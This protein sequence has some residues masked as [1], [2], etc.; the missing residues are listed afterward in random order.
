MSSGRPRRALTQLRAGGVNQ[1]SI[2][3]LLAA[4]AVPLVEGNACTF[5]YRGPADAVEV[6]HAVV[7]LPQPL[8]LKR[9]RHSDLWHASIELPAGSRVEYRLTVRRNGMEESILDPL[10]HRVAR[11]PVGE[12]SVLEAAGYETPWWTQH[13]PE[14]VP[15]EHTE[16][17][18][19]SRALR[20]RAHV[21]LYSPARMREG[22]R[23]PL[24][25]LH[26]GGDFI[27]HAAMVD[28]LDNLMDRRLMADCVVAMTH[29]GDRLTEYAASPAHSRFLTTELVPELEK[30]LPLRAEPAGRALAGASFGAIAATAAAW[31][32]PGF[33]GSLLLQ[34][35]SFLWT[36]AGR[37]HPGGPD[38]D[39]VVRFVNEVRAAPQRIVERAFLSFGAFETS[40]LRNL[41]MVSTLQ[42]LATEVR[43]VESLDG[44]TWTGWRDRLLDALTWLFPGETRYVYP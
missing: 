39:P 11:G 7:E 17:D 12:M 35:G 20:R 2:D 15:G 3:A 19:P 44:H 29:P 40:A 32:A 33:Y 23:L 43:V 30:H 5:L 34:S 31:H 22:D 41:A 6:N 9:L 18:M 10:N 28:V 1:A 36:R 4:H 37:E 27:N 14:T 16:F 13:H 38:F 24:L 26:D 8:P 25:I 21:T 42:R